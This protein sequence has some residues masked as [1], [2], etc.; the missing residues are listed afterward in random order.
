[1][2]REIRKVPNSWEHPKNDNGCYKPLYDKSATEDFKLWL[3]E[4]EEFKKTELERVAKDY[5]YDVNDPYS[6]F[7]DWHG[8][9][10]NY[11]YCRPNWDEATATWWQ[12]YETVSEGTPVSPPF[13]TADELIEYLVENG[14]FWDQSRRRAQYSGMNCDPWKRE[15]AERFVNGPGWAPSFIASSNGLQSGVEALA[16]IPKCSDGD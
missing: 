5:K 16:N 15:V 10:P 8:P 11:E 6:A 4:Y 9:P 3:E 14:D 2:G 13:E 1:M 7:C 12:V